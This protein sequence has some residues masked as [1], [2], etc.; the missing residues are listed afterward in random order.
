[1]NTLGRSSI[2]SRLRVQGT[3]LK[4]QLYID[5]IHLASAVYL[6]LCAPAIWTEIYLLVNI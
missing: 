6:L 2:N 1:M 4:V 3:R 5:Y